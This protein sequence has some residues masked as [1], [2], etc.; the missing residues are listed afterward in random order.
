MQNT[1]LTAASGLAYQLNL[2]AG[3]TVAGAITNSCG[4]T[5]T[6]AVDATQVTLTDGTVEAADSCLTTVPVRATSRGSYVL[7][8]SAF[9]DV[10]GMENVVGTSTLTV[11]RGR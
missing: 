4:G 3:L 2:P 6:G 7:T 5:T 10:A 11:D 1:L 9:T 8:R